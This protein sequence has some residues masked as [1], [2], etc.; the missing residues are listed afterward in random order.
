M[1]TQQESP[2]AQKQTTTKKTE[3]GKG[4]SAKP[5]GKTAPAATTTTKQAGKP[6]ASKMSSIQSQLVSSLS[7]LSAFYSPAQK[8]AAASKQQEQGLKSIMKKN[9]V[10]DKQGSKGT[11]KNLKFVGVNGGYET[12]SSEESSGD[13]KSKVDAEEE[14][15]FEPDAVMEKDKESEETAEIQGAE[16]LSEGGGAA[17]EEKEVEKGL[18]DLESGHELLG[19]QDEGEKVD[20]GF[21]DACI[22]VKDRMEEVSSP[23]KEMRQVL[24]VLY[25]EWF[26]V[27]SQKESEADTVRLYLRQV[28]MTT[29]TLLPYVV[30]LTDGNGNMALH[31]SVSHS[32][33]PVVKLL[34]DT[35]LCET[36]N[37]NKAGYT[38]VML[39]A[40]TAA[41]SPDDLEVAQQLLK[42]G[43]V[44]ARSRQAGQTALMLAVSHGRVAMVKLLLSCGADV[45]AQ[46]REGSTPLMCACEHGHTH[47]ARLLLETGRCDTSLTDKNGHTA[48]SVAEAAAHQDVADLLKAHASQPTSAADPL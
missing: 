10:A 29:P 31:Y 12:T 9:G 25:Q 45:N 36:D 15:K 27:S 13:E 5:A 4:T 17:G 14:E 41:E 46:D 37:V 42:L 3:A 11:K 24:V 23:D 38:P 19:E 43:D 18:L 16:A 47:I 35:G 22:Y 8:A 44:N 2:S 39:A 28:G 1:A 30:N 34:L 7:V 6:G 48:L 40:L 26:K 33:F 20:K 21:I 32:N